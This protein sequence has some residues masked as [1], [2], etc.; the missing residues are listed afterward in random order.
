M[1]R[2]AVLQMCAGIDPAANTATLVDAAARAAD[3]GVAMLFTPEMSGLIDRNRKRAAPH[4]VS[5]AENPVLGAV[6]EAA[7]RHGLW[8]A[9][10]SLAVAG[11]DGAYANRSLLVGPD[12]AVAARYDKIHMFD[13]D[14]GSGES[15][16]ESRTYAPGKKAA[17]ARLPWGRLGMTV[18][19]DV[20]FPDLFRQL[21]IAALEGAAL[22][23][24]VAQ[25][26]LSPLFLVLLVALEGALLGT[27]AGIQSRFVR[28]EQ[29][30]DRLR[31]SERL[32]ALSVGVI[33]IA[34]T[35]GI[36]FWF[37][38]HAG[39][40]VLAFF[41]DPLGTMSAAHLALPL[42]ITTFGAGLDAFRDHRHLA[43]SPEKFV[44]TPGNN[45][46]ARW[47]TLI[48]GG[49][50]GF[51]PIVA[52]F[53]GTIAVLRRRS[54][55]AESTAANDVAAEAPKTWKNLALFLALGTAALLI[56]H[57][58][59]SG[60]TGWSASFVATKV[61][62]EGL[63]IALPWIAVA[64]KAKEQT[65]DSPEATPPASSPRKRKGER[66]FSR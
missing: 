9:L 42:A 48:F 25:D 29:R 38:L 16:R 55:R 21:A 47:Y 56:L 40:S 13:V 50:P 39:D 32:G 45:A 2:I 8:I 1:T 62:F 44:S 53:A 57:F 18:C 17:I 30:M 27:I 15:Y 36:A 19:Y 64:A 7:A 31:I 24:L 66:K 60:P 43:Q 65:P 26:R 23:K 4:I 35:Y 11:G 63:L 61:L 37:I 3:E 34:L 12:G 10:G 41:H 54:Q 33:W 14:L 28:P 49:I 46:G 58:S 22:V 52:L 20:R 5:E 51:A 59:L 6:R